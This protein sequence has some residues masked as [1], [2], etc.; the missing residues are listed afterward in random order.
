MTKKHS[1]NRITMASVPANSNMIPRVTY[2]ESMA[3][4]INAC[5]F[6]CDF[7]PLSQVSLYTSVNAICRNE[8]MRAQFYAQG[9]VHWQWVEKCSVYHQD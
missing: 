2:N 6:T 9:R 7:V 4:K 5:H 1:S 8:I 3:N